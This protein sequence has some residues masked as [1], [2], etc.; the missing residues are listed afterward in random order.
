[1]RNIATVLLRSA[2][3]LSADFVLNGDEV[4]ARAV[5]RSV[6]GVAIGDA[7]QTVILG[8]AG[9]AAGGDLAITAHLIRSTDAT[10][11][12]VASLGFSALPPPGGRINEVPFLKFFL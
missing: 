9:E 12:A 8:S 5:C 11:T 6:A 1:M 7:K 10:Y 2:S 3:R 4:I